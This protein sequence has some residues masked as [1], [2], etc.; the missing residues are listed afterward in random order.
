MND[1]LRFYINICGTYTQLLCEANTMLLMYTYNIQTITQYT[2][3]YQTLYRLK[4]N[5]V[6]NT[7]YTQYCREYTHTRNVDSWLR[8]NGSAVGVGYEDSFI[9]NQCKT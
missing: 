9:Y 8:R 2:T 3:R 4:S 7:L 6:Q 1:L 5:V